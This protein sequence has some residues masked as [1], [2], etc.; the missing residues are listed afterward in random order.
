MRGLGNTPLIRLT[1]SKSL[2]D[3]LCNIASFQKL[4]PPSYQNPESSSC[5]G[6]S[7]SSAVVNQAARKASVLTL[8][9][10][11]FTPA[12]SACLFLRGGHSLGLS[13]K[14]ALDTSPL[15]EASGS[16]ISCE[17]NATRSGESALQ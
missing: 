15:L 3:L 14:S 16:E 1:C 7:P 6:G 9:I 2:D 8:R 4:L 17:I 13:T 12:R 10:S 11:I 5:G